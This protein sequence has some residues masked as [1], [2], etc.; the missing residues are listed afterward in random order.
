MSESDSERTEPRG[1]VYVILND[2]TPG[3]FK[4]GYTTKDPIDRALEFV[5]TGTTGTFV[6]IYHALV[7]DPF[8]VE[9]E[10]HKRLRLAGIDWEREWFSVCPDRAK[11]EIRTAAGTVFY[12]DTTARWHR[13]QRKPKAYVFELLAEAKAAAE[14]R[15]R[16]QEEAELAARIA[17]ENARIEAAQ[18][19]ERRRQQEELQEASRRAEEA[20][21][22]A[23]EAERLQIEED[24]RREQAAEAHEKRR[25][26]LAKV[27]TLALR[28]ACFAIFVEISYLALGPYSPSR[29]A[30]LQQKCRERNAAVLAS[31]GKCDAISRA[32]R[33]A[34]VEFDQLPRRAVDL[35]T[36][37]ERLAKDEDKAKLKIEFEKYLL[38]EFQKKYVPLGYV[39][40]AVGGLSAESIASEWRIRKST[41]KSAE[42]AL[43]RIHEQQQ[44]LSVQRADLPAQEQ[45][46][47]ARKSELQRSLSREEKIL[48][49]AKASLQD[50]RRNVEK[51]LRHNAYFP[52]AEKGRQ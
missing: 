44:E 51:A 13:L 20:M 22:L 27:K 46:A 2:D 7:A 10:V 8:A 52:W 43:N 32:L 11:E 1:W 26:D 38:D 19:A 29:I 45:A 42:S 31:Q 28:A 33:S 9:Q 3:K 37:R 39:S 15:R 30:E 21:Q 17:E 12:E 36:N 5:S 34:T 40:G 23:A 47:S 18:E 35:R 41:V 50:A 25:R 48:V 14:N 16:E 6:V 49:G 4:I 24:R